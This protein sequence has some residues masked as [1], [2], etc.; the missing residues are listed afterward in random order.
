MM[1][2]VKAPSPG[3]SIMV[4]S[5]MEWLV[6]HKSPVM[7]AQPVVSIETE[8]VTMT[9]TA[10]ASGVIEILVPEGTEIPVGTVIARIDTSVAVADLATSATSSAEAPPAAGHLTQEALAESPAKR[11]VHASPAAAK[12]LR[13]RGLDVRDVA[14]TGKDARVTK[15]DALRAAPSRKGGEP[16]P[17]KD[18]AGVRRERMSQ[19]RQSLSR[20]LVAAKNE[21]AMLTTF[22]E[23][24]LGQLQALRK[25]AG[26][27][28]LAKEGVKLGLMGFFVRAATRAL[29][30]FPRANAFIDGQDMLYHEF[31]DMG[32]AVQ[33]ERGLMVPVVRG[34]EKRSIADIE[35]EILR[36]ATRAREG[37]MT[38]EEM[39]GGTFTISNGG[40][41]GSMLSTPILN[42]P[43]AAVMGMH[44]IIDRPVAREGQVVIRP[45]MYL[46]LS[47]DHRLLDGRESVGFLKRVRELLESPRELLND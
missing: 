33:T 38:L 39:A 20:R 8:K 35:R 34:C 2:E 1:I 41:F 24:D 10:E 45:M 16:S 7:K 12:I 4:V 37:Q 17:P 30:E 13:E 9:V 44:A 26:E 23:V 18:R 47:Y 14:G 3:E 32:V 11:V 27:R 19:L 28:F 15:D 5:I 40:I 31:V 43:Q 22:N 36:L 6:G 25:E 46:A 21:T 29:K 42:P